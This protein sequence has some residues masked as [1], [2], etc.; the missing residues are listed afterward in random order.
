MFAATS[1]DDLAEEQQRAI[2]EGVKNKHSS[3]NDKNPSSNGQIPIHSMVSA[4]AS[5]NNKPHDPNLAPSGTFNRTI[6]SRQSSPTDDVT[7]GGSTMKQLTGVSEKINSVNLSSVQGSVVQNNSALKENASSA[8]LSATGQGQ[9]GNG[10]QPSI[11]SVAPSQQ[12]NIDTS[13]F[14][15]Q[16]G[17][18]FYH[19]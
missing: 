3:N 7:N 8:L 4:A 16:V 1:N 2:S 13:G 19:F 17:A 15:G 11:S 14:P 6:G 10:Q 18:A 12:I 9:S 5:T